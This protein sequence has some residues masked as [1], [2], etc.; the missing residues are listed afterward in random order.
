MRNT[1]ASGL[2]SRVLLILSDAFPPVQFKEVVKRNKAYCS[3][4]LYLKPRASYL[5]KLGEQI[6]P[7]KGVSPK[8][9]NCLQP[10]PT[11]DC[12]PCWFPLAFQSPQI[13]DLRYDAARGWY[14]AD[15]AGLQRTWV[16]HMLSSARSGAQN[17]LWTS[18]FITIVS[19]SYWQTEE[20]L[21]ML[22]DESVGLQLRNVSQW[23]ELARQVRNPLSNPES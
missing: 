1:L 12:D 22:Q 10:R 2:P 23:R 5:R 21:S 13:W 18:R 4:L 7:K 17:C 16:Q 8:Y 20:Q 6:L 14:Q 3:M 9:S 15:T 19:Q 11:A